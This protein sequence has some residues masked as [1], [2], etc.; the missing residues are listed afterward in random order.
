ML[1]TGRGQK[2]SADVL[3]AYVEKIVGDVSWTPR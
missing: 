1:K 3:G 2:R